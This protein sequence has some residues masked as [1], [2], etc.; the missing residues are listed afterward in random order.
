MELIYVLLTI[1][2][3]RLIHMVSVAGEVKLRLAHSQA[4][5]SAERHALAIS[6]M[7]PS[8]RAMKNE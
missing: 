3:I 8:G 4:H 1:L 2:R 7:S 6:L 5:Q